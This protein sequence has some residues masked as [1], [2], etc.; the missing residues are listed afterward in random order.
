MILF[1]PESQYYM[2]ITHFLPP[3]A[4]FSDGL[5]FQ[6]QINMHIRPST[7]L[8]IHHD[9]AYHSEP[10]NHTKNIIQLERKALDI[11]THTHSYAP[12]LFGI[13]QNVMA[14]LHVISTFPMYISHRDL[15]C[16]VL[17]SHTHWSCVHIHND[18]KC[19]QE[20]TISVNH[21]I[22]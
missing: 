2:I 6:Y 22:L 19:I 18:I 8:S 5:L 16:T 3:G 20:R 10:G 21:I 9:Y 13:C 7:Y 4:S 1:L 15:L 12:G 11:H 17:S 14:S